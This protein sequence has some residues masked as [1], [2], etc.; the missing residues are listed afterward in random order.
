[1]LAFPAVAADAD[2]GWQRL[3]LLDKAQRVNL[4]FW[5]GQARSG[6]ILHLDSDGLTLVTG[7]GATPLKK[8]DIAKVVKVSRPQGAKWGSLV[9][10]GIGVPLGV[11][12][13]KELVH[14][15]KS[16]DYGAGIAFV[17]ALWAGIGAGIGAAV[18][19]ESAIY[20]A[21]AAKRPAPVRS[22]DH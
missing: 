9:G 6:T 3:A 17:G 13:T 2:S 18:G 11:S 14:H 7:K 4:Y 21:D 8:E 20:R 10:F 12:Y 5:N 1:M 16:S 15:P 19:K 22:G